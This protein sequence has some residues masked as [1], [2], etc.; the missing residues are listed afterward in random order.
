M[1]HQKAICT[2]VIK[3]K[4]NLFK[5]KNNNWVLVRLL[6]KKELNQFKKDHL[7]VYVAMML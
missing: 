7:Q 1:V 6:A 2:F 5:S 3:N 4:E